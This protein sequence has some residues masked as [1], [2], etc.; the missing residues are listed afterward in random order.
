MWAQFNWNHLIVSGRF[1][2]I[3]ITHML[4]VT[5]LCIVGTDWRLSYS[6]TV[7]TIYNKCSPALLRNWSPEVPKKVQ[8]AC[9]WIKRFYFTSCL[10]ASYDAALNAP[11]RGW[12]TLSG[13]S[14]Q[15]RASMWPW[16]WC[17]RPITNS[18][19]L[20]TDRNL[21]ANNRALLDF[22]CSVLQ[23]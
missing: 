3:Q 13:L 12:S 14:Q 2:N 7:L 9:I 11:K 10:E 21:W 19:A 8:Y 18:R 17:I 16:I 23:L 15:L 20:T 5:I 6:N 4:V 22:V 1:N